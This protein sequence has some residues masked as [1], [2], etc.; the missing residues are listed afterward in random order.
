MVVVL[1]HTRCGA[2][3]G[4]CD[5]VTLGNLTGL[6]A[7]IQP[8]IDAVPDDGTDRSSKN[9]AFTTRVAHANVRHQIERIRKESPVLQELETQGRIRIVGAVYDVETGLCAWLE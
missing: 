7:K 5:G 1:G 2:V 6:L 8:A 3:K 4:A 9:E